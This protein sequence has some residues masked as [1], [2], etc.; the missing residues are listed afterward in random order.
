MSEIDN[1]GGGFFALNEKTVA[2]A[3]V[4]LLWAIIDSHRVVI[5]NLIIFL[6]DKRLYSVYSGGKVDSS[7]ATVVITEQQKAGHMI[8]ISSK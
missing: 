4:H 2:G 7:T 5:L 8:A 3:C 1:R 6:P